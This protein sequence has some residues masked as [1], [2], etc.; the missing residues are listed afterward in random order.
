MSIPQLHPQGTQAYKVRKN[1]AQ[2]I[3]RISKTWRVS[4]NSQE[5][6]IA[7]AGQIPSQPRHM[8]QR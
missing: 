5:I 8:M 6:S 4:R 7:A 1:T 3:D 2:I